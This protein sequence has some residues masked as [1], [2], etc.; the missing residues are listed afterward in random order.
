MGKPTMVFYLPTGGSFLSDVPFKQAVKAFRERPGIDQDALK[1]I[2]D[3]GRIRTFEECVK[4]TTRE[5][6]L[7]RAADQRGGKETL[8]E[9]DL[10]KRD[11]VRRYQFV[12]D[13]C[14]ADLEGKAEDSTLVYFVPTTGWCQ[15]EERFEKIIQR[16]EQDPKFPWELFS[17]IVEPE[18]LVQVLKDGD[19]KYPATSSISKSLRRFYGCDPVSALRMQF[20]ATG[21]TRYEFIRDFCIVDLSPLTFA[22]EKDVP[23]Q[24]FYVPDLESMSVNLSYELAVE[25]IKASSENDI[26]L[27]ERIL[28]LEDRSVLTEE[29]SRIKRH[30]EG[31]TFIERLCQDFGADMALIAGAANFPRYERVRNWYIADVQNLGV[32]APTLVM[33]A[34]GA[35]WV[36][37]EMSF[38]DAVDGIRQA[39][40]E[41]DLRWLKSL[42]GMNR[43][44]RRYRTIGPIRFKD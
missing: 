16:L 13:F 23:A 6:Y 19:Q 15:R 37:S 17:R 35:E 28:L 5:E 40:D 41:T 20:S 22:T 10:K 11:D 44:D 34:P 4:V 21:C 30:Y 31:V 33:A 25:K 7:E 32:H 36:L 27:M 12:G 29:D 1:G 26:K 42:K 43:D 38:E 8:I 3:N 39:N 2:S 14:V 24:V 18:T 9:Q